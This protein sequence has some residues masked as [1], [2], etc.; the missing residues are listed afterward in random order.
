MGRRIRVK[1]E[2]KLPEALKGNGNKDY[3]MDIVYWAYTTSEQAL[4]G[5]CK[6][7]GFN[8]KKFEEI[9]EMAEWDEKK[10]KFKDKMYRTFA[11]NR[12]EK[13]EMRQR[14]IDELESHDLAAIQQLVDDFD[15]KVK[16]DGY[17]VR[18]TDGNIQR[19]STG[20]PFIRTV[21]KSLKEKIKENIEL[22]EL[23]T[24]ALIAANT[25]LQMPEPMQ[26]AGERPKELEGE[27]IDLEN[28]PVGEHDTKNDK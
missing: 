17:L 7:F 13:M 4:K 21:P 1:S 2:W 25:N 27:V 9:V 26:I 10:E 22:L 15:E 8:Q 19:D 12:L 20:N 16:T 24:R 3:P 23:N 11:K 18:D 28:M 5:F 14:I 6:R